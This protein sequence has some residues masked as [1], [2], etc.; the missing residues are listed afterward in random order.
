MQKLIQHVCNEISFTNINRFNL[1]LK[2]ESKKMLKEVNK[3]VINY[4][5]NTFFTTLHSDSMKKLCTY[6]HFKKTYVQEQYLREVE[7][8]FH[9]RML[10]RFRIS[11]HNLYIECGRYKKVK[12]ED[13]VC[14]LCDMNVVENEYHF[15]M[16]CS[17]YNNLREFYIKEMVLQY[18]DA[19]SWDA[20]L[21]IMQLSDN[22]NVNK[23]ASF[24]YEAMEKQKTHMYLYN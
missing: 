4:Y 1:K 2:S 20:F 15:F 14:K 9:R 8:P 16:Q 23:V 11:A 17:F 10:T 7:N 13:R 18:N 6:R 24:I 22:I 5:E 12:R 19:Y 3:Y 21:Y